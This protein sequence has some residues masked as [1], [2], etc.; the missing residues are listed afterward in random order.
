LKRIVELTECENWELK[1]AAVFALKNL[2]FKCAKEVRTSVMKE[3]TYDRLL[4]LLDDS[5]YKV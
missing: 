5:H 4:D 2:L 3:L 1:N